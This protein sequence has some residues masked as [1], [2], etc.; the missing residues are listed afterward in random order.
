MPPGGPGRSDYI[1][2]P[3]WLVFDFS[4][5]CTRRRVIVAS[6]CGGAVM[7][8]ILMNLLHDLL[9][10]LLRGIYDIFAVIRDA[11]MLLLML[12]WYSCQQIVT[13]EE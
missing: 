7:H 3:L 8:N 4:V 10:G 1:K 2:L 6:A 9:V 5:S 11:L 13:A 12:S